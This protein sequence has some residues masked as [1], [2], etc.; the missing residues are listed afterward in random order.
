MIPMIGK[1]MTAGTAGWTLEKKLR[2]EFPNRSGDA[3][4]SD[5]RSVVPIVD[6]EW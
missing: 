4:S 1:K 6:P 3:E 2:K 5:V